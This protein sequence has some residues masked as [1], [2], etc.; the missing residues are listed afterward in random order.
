VVSPTLM[1][2]RI[3]KGIMDS[4]S[5]RYNN[6]ITLLSTLLTPNQAPPLSSSPHPY[7]FEHPSCPLLTCPLLPPTPF[8]SHPLPLPF[9]SPP[10][11][12]I[13]FL[14]GTLPWQGLKAKNASK[15]YL[16]ILSKKQSVSIAQLCQGCPSQ[17]AE[18][19]VRALHCTVSYSAVLCCVVLN[20]CGLL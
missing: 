18:F 9:F 17:F 8:F 13:Y 16:L 5:P 6:P 3:L 10:H 20:R 11:P 15:K 1:L 12:Q 14:K 7:S 19:L 2:I 4:S